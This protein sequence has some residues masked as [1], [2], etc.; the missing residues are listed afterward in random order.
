MFNLRKR[1]TEV[2]ISLHTV[3]MEDSV[4]SDRRQSLPD[5]EIDSWLTLNPEFT[6]VMDLSVAATSFF[7][8]IV[9]AMACIGI[10]NLMMMAVFERTREM[11][12]LAALGMKVRQVMSLFLLEGAMIGA[13]LCR[14]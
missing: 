5:Y 2:A 1:A 11:G 7:G 13:S 9:V 14:R 8:F 12:V 3:G 4:I 6:Q 10:L